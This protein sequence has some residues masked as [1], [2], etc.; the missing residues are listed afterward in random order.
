MLVGCV[1]GKF[2]PESI[3][4]MLELDYTP[5][6]YL[7]NRTGDIRGSSDIFKKL[8][9]HQKVIAVKDARNRLLKDA[10]EL[11][12]DYLFWIDADVIVSPDALTKMTSCTPK[13]ECITAVVEY[14]QGITVLDDMIGNTPYCKWTG[15]HCILISR[16]LHE[17]VGYFDAPADFV[18]EDVDYHR[19]A[20]KLG[21]NI[22]VAKDVIVEHQYQKTRIDDND[23]REKF[24]PS[25]V[26]RKVGDVEDIPGSEINIEEYLGG[27]TRE[28][29]EVLAKYAAASKVGIV[30]IG[31][32][33]GKS[34]LILLSNSKV[35]ITCIDSYRF[36]TCPVYNYD[37][38]QLK[39]RKLIFSPDADKVSSLIARKRLRKILQSF[40]NRGTHI[41]KDSKAAWTDVH[42]R[43]FDL[44][45]IDGGHRYDEVKSD[46]DNYVPRMKKPGVVILHDYVTNIDGGGVMKFVKD[47]KREGYSV[48][49]EGACAIIKLGV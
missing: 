37:Q 45:F 14:R 34:A 2:V 11:D 22:F 17:K 13:E 47:L 29:G 25:F 23:H 10:L 3:E 44:L 26:I 31:S 39:D 24:H 48:E 20:R 12:W 6:D 15:W 27:I 19:R 4:S 41:E 35:N 5:I 32:M 46:W 16:N 8:E 7:F 43:S 30:E 1:I 40:K 36:G 49:F 21:F 33:T 28:D 38:I 9:Y 18:G 42:I